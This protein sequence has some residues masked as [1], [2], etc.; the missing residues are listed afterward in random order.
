MLETVTYIA[1]LFIGQVLNEGDIAVDA[2]AGNGKDTVFLAEHVGETG[3]VYAFDIQEIALDR[4]RRLL[5][6][7]HLNHRC[8]LIRA[9]HSKL[10]DHIPASLH[11]HIRAVMFN[12]GYLPGGDRSITTDVETTMAAVRSAFYLLNVGG[13]ISIVV[14]P[15]HPA[16]TEESEALIH[17]S[18]RFPRDIAIAVQ[19][20]RLNSSDRSPYLI[21][22][23]KRRDVPASGSEFLQ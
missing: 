6:E 21:L 4:T 22:I 3:H 12:L 15:G 11:K 18:R 5:Q 10:L 14:Y 23:E 16:G 9:C 2:T 8:T 1:Q 7:F 13:R 19:Y 20:R 17:W